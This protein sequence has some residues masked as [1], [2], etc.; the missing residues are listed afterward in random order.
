MI[1][2][3]PIVCFHGCGNLSHLASQYLHLPS[4]MCDTAMLRVD[5]GQTTWSTLGQGGNLLSSNSKIYSVTKVS[6]QSRLSL[7]CVLFLSG[8]A[9]E[10]NTTHVSCVIWFM[11]SVFCFK[12]IVSVYIMVW[13]YI[14]NTHVRGFFDTDLHEV[15]WHFATHEAVR[16][17]GF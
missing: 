6:L 9:I 12:L 15:S 7:Q 8:T 3:L 17:S 1:N 5:K 10:H 14:I 16:S 4:A 11:N 2:S 13:W